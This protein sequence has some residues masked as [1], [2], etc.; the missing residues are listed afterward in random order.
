[1]ETFCGVVADFEKWRFI[2]VSLSFALLL[3]L[4]WCAQWQGHGRFI[5]L[6]I[7]RLASST[8][9]LSMLTPYMR[10]IAK[11]QANRS[12]PSIIAVLPVATGVCAGATCTLD[13]VS[14]SV[15]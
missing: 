15:S 12:V 1:M 9:A 4:G 7:V 13:V 3:A 10:T 5:N 6:S 11:R 14:P 2:F 8:R